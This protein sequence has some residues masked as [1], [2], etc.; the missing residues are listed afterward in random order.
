MHLRNIKLNNFRLVEQLDLKM[1]KKLTLLVGPNGAGKTAVLDAVAIGLGAVLTRLPGAEGRTFRKTGDIRQQENGVLAPYSRVTLE[2]TEGITW[3]RTQKRDAAGST[4]KEIPGAKGLKQL[5]TFLDDHIIAPMNRKDPFTLPLFAYYGVHR[6]LLELPQR[7]KGFP[8]GH[9]RIEALAGALNATSNFK[10]AFI[11]F[12]NKENEEIRLQKKL[13]N[14]DATLPDLDAVRRAISRMFPDITEPHIQ[15]IPLRFMV[16]K[17]GL[18]LAID[19]LSDGYKT[20]F[21]L[22][23]DLSAR[24]AMGNP[25][26]DDPLQSPAVVM[27]DEVDLHLHP[28]W[29]RTVITDLLRTF[30]N[31]QFLVSTHSPFIIEAIN[32]SLKR[33]KIADIPIDDPE[34]SHI[35]PLSPDDI[36]AYAMA[37]GT[38]ESMLDRNLGLLDNHLLEHLNAI[39]AVYD[40]MRDLEWESSLL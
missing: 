23:I 13:R 30:P 8:A 20:L 11:W 10:S 24:M 35:S 2:T 18:S 7:R 39:N 40:K 37:N 27:I 1:G 28:A 32:N 25:H 17:N 9:E 15:A 21:G 33:H 29:Q 16:R 34:I 31:T 14:F 12:Y 26:L 36:E 3:D 19:Q 6:A 5:E 4:Q 22:V 38:V